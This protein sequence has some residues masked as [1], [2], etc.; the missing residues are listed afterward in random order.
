M[1][2]T[3]PLENKRCSIGMKATCCTF[4]GMGSN[5]RKLKRPSAIPT[6]FLLPPS[7]SEVSVGGRHWG[8]PRPAGFS[9][10]YS[11]SAPA[12]FGSSRLARLQT[13]RSAATGRV[14][15]RG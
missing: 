14:H 10:S 3:E 8:R 6:F 1:D 4:N 5:P 2:Y 12:A 11:R 15:E 13:A 9:T 7:Q